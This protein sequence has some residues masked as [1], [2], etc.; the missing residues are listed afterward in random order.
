MSTISKVGRMSLS[1]ALLSALCVPLAAQGLRVNA[2]LPRHEG[3]AGGDTL[4]FQLSPN[5]L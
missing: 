3:F 2:E 1:C 5:G 4:A